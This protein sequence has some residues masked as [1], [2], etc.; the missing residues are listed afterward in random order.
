MYEDINQIAGQPFPPYVPPPRVPIS[1]MGLGGGSVSGFDVS[2][3]AFRLSPDANTGTSGLVGMDTK[4]F[5]IKN[6]SSKAICIQLA[7]Y[8]FQSSS[9]NEPSP[10]VEIYPQPINGLGIEYTHIPPNS[11][12]VDLGCSLMDAVTNNGTYHMTGTVTLTQLL[13]VAYDDYTNPSGLF[14]LPTDY[15]SFVPS[16]VLAQSFKFQP[17]VRVNYDY[18][19]V[20]NIVPL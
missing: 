13:G 11:D 16:N 15:A 12:W 20:V 2:K 8:T 5:Q 1:D 14:G 7:Q 3:L 9:N 19:F 18:Q 17:N 6:N 10:K 4:I